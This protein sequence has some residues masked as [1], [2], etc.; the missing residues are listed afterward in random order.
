VSVSR[1]VVADAEQILIVS[2]IQEG[3]G[4][5]ARLFLSPASTAIVEDPCYEGALLAFQSSGARITSVAVDHDGL[6]P[7]ELPHEP[8]SLLYLTPA[9]QYPTGHALEPL[10]RAQI[11]AWARSHG[12]YIVE[13]DYDADIHHDGGRQPALAALAP[14]CTILLGTFSTSLGAGVRLG[15]MIVPP[16]LIAASRAEK[17]LHSGGASWLEQAA[18]AE[19]LRSG[20]YNAHLTRSRAQYKESRDALLGALRRH[21]GNVEISGDAAG[22]HV[23]WP[24]PAGVPE[25]ARLEELARRHR[26]AVYCL[27]SA[28]A[29]QREPSA[30]A[31]R[32]LVLG[33]CCLLP[34]Q[35][36]EGIARL[37][38]AV[39]D[40]LDDHHDFVRELMLDGPPHL[41]RPVAAIRKAPRISP[42]LRPPPALRTVARRRSASKRPGEEP[43]V[44][45][46]V[47]A[48]YR[49]PI[50]GLS[51]QP[52]QGVTLEAGKP[53]P[54]DRVFALVRPNVPVDVEAPRWAKKGLFLMLMLD[55]SLARVQTFLDEESLELA[56]V[57]APAPSA[58]P[59]AASGSSVPRTTTLLKANLGN[60]EGRAA[61]E[62][63]FR[64]HVPEL[65]AAP[66]LVRAQNDAHFMD[67][68][69]SVMSCINLATLRSLEAQWGRAIHPL[70]FRANFYVDGLRPWEEF[71]WIGSDIQLGDVLF[72][73]DRRNGR[74]GATNVNPETGGRDMDIPGSL[75]KSFGHK[76][77]GI[78]LVARTAGKV[79]V[80]DPVTVP[81]LG[82]PNDAVQ[83]SAPPR[84]AHDAFICRGCYYIYD[85]SR[86]APGQGQ[87]PP[88]ASLSD[89]FRCPDCGT[90]KVNFRPYIATA[91]GSASPA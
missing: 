91:R 87:R 39:D 40:T 13:D 18:M 76:D 88:F 27:A 78:Y 52:M 55:D 23:F 49:Y 67:K 86:T 33:Y 31:R 75:R 71:D 51:A 59:A 56:V 83:P 19:F 46:S 29:I 89:D 7:A 77:L 32:S 47:R 42:Q 50:K 72:R 30:L 84:T 57:G 68:P 41:D 25:A 28:G 11:V 10:R 54:F 16:N 90:E 45:R 85:E 1:G 9:H 4:L 37:S 22:M 48:I 44:M 69:D 3:L 14:D 20:A 35:I 8:A 81:D 21:F 60:R 73:V 80:G 64:E 36:E 79:V 65:R 62:A 12:C 53:F 26:V 2:S 63:F 66:R 34:K 24:L 61:V 74:C 58:L 43:T 38:D 17:A 15:Y 5:C 82:T 70:R 6:R